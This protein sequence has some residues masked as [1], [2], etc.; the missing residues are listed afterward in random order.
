[1]TAGD[2]FARAVRDLRD[3]S[4]SARLDAGRLLE[5][6][7]GRDAAWLLA[8]GDAA[9]SEREA[10]RYADAVARRARGVPVA[11]II[12]SVGFYGRSFAVT[13]DV[14]VPRPESELLIDLVLEH[15]RRGNRAAAAPRVLDVGT[16]SGALAITL[17]LEL[18]EATVSAVDISLPS[19][20]VARAN[21][22]TLGVAERVAFFAGD[23]SDAV[24]PGTRYD[25]IVANLPY[26]PTP[27]LAPAP[28]PTAFEPRLA[29]DGG[30]DGLDVYR[31]FLA[32]AP[33]R[34][35]ARGLLLMEAAPGTTRPL[36][37][38]ASSAFP[39]AAAVGVRADLSGRERV[40]SVANNNTP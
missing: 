2:A 4:P 31:R 40:V 7:L 24:P 19:L 23:L 28:D 17:A 8:H 12:G 38:L 26:V 33:G 3:V 5:F 27:A 34:L 22:A 14:L 37:R 11:Y 36:E 13:P 20:A 16:G 39:A 1:M 9:L 18:P 21:A 6:V 10:A 30:P 35:A 25:A 32:H 29:L 15:L